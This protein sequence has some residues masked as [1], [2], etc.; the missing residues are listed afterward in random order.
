M[1]PCKWRGATRCC[2]CRPPRC[3]FIRR[4]RR[5][6]AGVAAREGTEVARERT[7]RLRAADGG[8][9]ARGWAGAALVARAWAAPAAHRTRRVR[10]DGAIAAVERGRWVEARRAARW[11]VPRLVADRSPDAGCAAYGRAR[12]MKAKK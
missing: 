11:R 8:V 7:S 10:R 1:F 5:A 3:G 4:C 12:R 2:A 6:R 9:R